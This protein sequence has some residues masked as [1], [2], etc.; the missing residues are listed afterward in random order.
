M[1]STSD[2]MSRALGVV[3]FIAKVLVGLIFL[4]NALGIVD[5]TKPADELIAFGVPANLAHAAVWSGRVVQLVGVLLLFG[6]TGWP[7][8]D[9][10][11]S[12]A[13]SRRRLSSLTASG[14]RAVK[15]GRRSSSTS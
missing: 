3:L 5:Q 10:C 7:P 15:R 9:V 11:C 14:L 12:S 2:F 4:M 6:T 13:F 1:G 8:S